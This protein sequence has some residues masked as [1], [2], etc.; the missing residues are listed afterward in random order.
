MTL[1]VL[2]N[3]R[4]YNELT[5]YM[6]L[7]KEVTKDKGLS[8]NDIFNV[9][10]Y[11]G[12]LTELT[13]MASSVANGNIVRH[14]FTYKEDNLY[15]LA[16]CTIKDFKIKKSTDA[17]YVNSFM[18]A[19]NMSDM[20][21]CYKPNATYDLV[22]D[23]KVL[24]ENIVSY[25]TLQIG[26]LHMLQLNFSDGIGLMCYQ[27]DVGTSS[28]FIPKDVNDFEDW[29]LRKCKASAY[30]GYMKDVTAQEL[31]QVEFEVENVIFRLDNYKEVILKK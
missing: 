6:N 8:A 25:D 30:Q 4:N 27:T 31:F 2:K 19:H 26:F 20:W 9:E 16:Y 21:F 15:G 14:W 22:V 10:E 1:E 23:D 29:Y 18:S 28:I 13:Y 24:V 11:D 12:D 17:E 7:M 5:N 3:I